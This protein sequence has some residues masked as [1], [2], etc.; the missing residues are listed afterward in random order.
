[1]AILTAG[2][3]ASPRYL[4]LYVYVCVCV[5]VCVR[6]FCLYFCIL[7]T[8]LPIKRHLAIGGFSIKTGRGFLEVVHA[9]CPESLSS[10][11]PEA[12][13]HFTVG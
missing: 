3:R 5:C 12:R 6:T 10:G 8:L 2:E 7:C 11:L 1:M 13:G 9:V 4:S